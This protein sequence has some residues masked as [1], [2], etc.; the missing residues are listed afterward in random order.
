[1]PSPAAAADAQLGHRKTP[2]RNPVTH[3]NPPKNQMARI[4]VQTLSSLIIR[5]EDTIFRVSDTILAVQSTVFRDMLSLP[6]P[7]AEDTV[8][9]CP[10]VLL[11]DTAEDTGNFPALA[12]RPP[13]LLRLLPAP[14]TFPILASVVRMSHKYVRKRALVHLSQ[15]HPPHARSLGCPARAALTEW[16]IA[17]HCF[18]RAPTRRRVDPAHELLPN[19]PELVQP[20]DRHGDR[21]Q[22]RG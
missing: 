16:L 20:P 4:P 5:T 14:K 6:T 18:D 8:D 12:N 22:R 7:A 15:A 1:M 11:P 17:G 10:F 9:G 19:L 2:R 3:Y 21:A 13:Q